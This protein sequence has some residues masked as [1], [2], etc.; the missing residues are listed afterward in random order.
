MKIMVEYYTTAG[1]RMTFKQITNRLEIPLTAMFMRVSEDPHIT[2]GVLWVGQ[3]G[4]KYYAL[5]T[6][7]AK[8]DYEQTNA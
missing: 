6:A 5:H 7:L 2:T 1:E 3:P 4:D 8:E